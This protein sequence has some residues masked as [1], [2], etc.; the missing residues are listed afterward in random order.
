MSAL[1]FMSPA[2]C[3]P[4]TLASPLE[5]GLVGAPESLRDLSPDGK[6]ELRGDLA[7]V[8]LAEGD[9]LIRLTPRRGFL[10]TGDPLAAIDRSRAN[11][12]LAYDMTGALGG[13]AFEGETLFRRLT[14]LDPGALPTAG[15]FA[16][17]SAILVR[18]EGERFRAYFPQELGHY[19]VEVVLDVLAGLAGGRSHRA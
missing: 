9:E 7:R 3:I 17:I 13:L 8:G 14:D 2:R 16:R 4:E 12:V 11:G 19:V 6:V 15:G 10:L 5:R 18:D 1:Y